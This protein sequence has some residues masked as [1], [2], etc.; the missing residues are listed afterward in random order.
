[1]FKDKSNFAFQFLIVMAVLFAA[2][3]VNG[4]KEITLVPVHHDDYTNLSY[5][6]SD[7]YETSNYIRP[8]STFLIYSMSYLSNDGYLSLQYLTLCLYILFVIYFLARLIGAKINFFVT[9]MISML[10]STLP[11]LVEYHFYTGLMTNLF[12]GLFG[13]MALLVWQKF[14]GSD[15]NGLVVTLLLLSAF[16]KEDFILPFIV[17]V[18]FSY[19]VESEIEDKD[20]KFKVH[21]KAGVT[22]IVIL[23][24]SMTY[25]SLMGSAFIS[26]DTDAYKISLNILDIMTGYQFYLMRDEHFL[27]MTVIYLTSSIL[28]SI[29]S[30]NR[31]KSI[32]HVVIISISILSL[33]GPYSL[34]SNHLAP[35]YS[36]MWFVW[37]SIAS[38]LFV[39]K[40][41]ERLAGEIKYIYPLVFIGLI[42]FYFHFKF[43]QSRQSIISWYE[44]QQSITLN[45]LNTIKSFFIL[46]P[47]VENVYII[48]PPSLSPWSHSSGQYLER[49]LGLINHWTVLVDK[50]D[51]FYIIGTKL[52]NITVM[53]KNEGGHNLYQ[54]IRFLDNG[55][56]ITESNK[57]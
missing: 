1:M 20:T 41:C 26:S 49:K 29:L 32:L 34:L 23:L 21:L 31:K 39:F 6:I 11:N 43:Y 28:Y 52:G 19:F 37:I 40:I 51:P 10:I 7:I 22:A 4:G 2:F 27:L 9:I 3:F 53:D 30:T 48:D 33:I 16:S 18:F 54:S 12:S 17:Y 42:I 5:F 25:N 13:M 36:F 15:H 44:N 46:H 55:N 14:K 47:E 50:S 38:C 45:V 57:K 8:I 24:L 56:Q 35:Y